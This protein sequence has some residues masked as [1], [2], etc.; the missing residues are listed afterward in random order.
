MGGFALRVER[1]SRPISALRRE[2][3]TGAPKSRRQKRI[4]ATINPA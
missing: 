2:I 3:A 4:G 1:L